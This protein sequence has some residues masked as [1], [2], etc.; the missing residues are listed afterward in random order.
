[1]IRNAYKAFLDRVDVLVQRTVG[2]PRDHFVQPDWL[3]LFDVGHPPSDQIIIAQLEASD[4]AF[5]DLL[6]LKKVDA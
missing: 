1:M 4:R 2:F 3:A 5:G 6:A